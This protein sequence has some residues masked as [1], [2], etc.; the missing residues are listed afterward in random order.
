[1]IDKGL[2]GVEFLTANTDVQAMNSC[3]APTK[4]Q[5][6]ERSANGL[7]VGCDPQRGAKA[8]QESLDVIQQNIQGS[9]MLFLTAGMGGGTGTG[10][11]PYIAEVAREM[12]I[13]TV[14]V[15]TKPF[16]FEGKRKMAVAEEWIERIM[17]A[18]DSIIVVPNQ[19]L[20]DGYGKLALPQAFQLANDILL[21]AVQGIT[22]I[23]Q[24]NGMMN[25]DMEDVRTIMHSSG[26]ALMGMGYAEGED[27]A[28]KAAEMATTN[29]LIE[30]AAVDGST[31]VLVNV[32]CNPEDVSLED[33]S[34]AVST[35]TDAAASDAVIK[36]GLVSAD[37]PG[38]QIRITVIATGFDVTQRPTVK[39]REVEET[40]PAIKTRSSTPTAVEV[41]STSTLPPRVRSKSDS[42]QV[43]L[44]IDST[45]VLDISDEVTSIPAFIQQM[46]VKNGSGS[47]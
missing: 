18:C 3:A 34:Q 36:P 2:M 8:C 14:A 25:V 45:D 40:R 1:M 23:V 33:F 9:E 35:I 29:H 37:M 16:H 38:G 12:G 43:A 7:G 24:L 30:N 47:K 6:G 19:R 17:E 22:D 5:L 39:E 31:G 44:P 20:L 11:L 27:R 26:R 46:H 15:V 13:L 41:R 32:T 21:Y 10:A 4:I 42:R 28:I